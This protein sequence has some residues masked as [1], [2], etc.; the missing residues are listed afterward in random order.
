MKR[1][2]FLFLGMLAFGCIAIPAEMAVES[3]PVDY[4]SLDSCQEACGDEGY[5]IGECKWPS[6]A[7]RTHLDLGS[8]VISGSKHCGKE[9]LCNCYCYTVLD[10]EHYTVEE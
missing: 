8:C 7:D 5:E 6:E 10:Y 9:G 3:E 2:I 1:M 4:A